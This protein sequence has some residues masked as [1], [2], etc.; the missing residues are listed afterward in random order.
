MSDT[1]DASTPTDATPSSEQPP[2]PAPSAPTPQPSGEE[3]RQQTF[4]ADY[5][6]KLRAESAR[7]RTEAKANADAAK[8]L[9]EIEDAQ[10]TEAQKAAEQLQALQQENARLQA[11]ALKAQVAASKGVPADLLSG[12]TED[13]LNAAADRLLAFKG[14]TPAPD[15]GAGNRGETLSPIDELRRALDQAIADG[16]VAA[17][18]TLKRR[19]AAQAQTS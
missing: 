12:T 15:F 16:N 11:E 13:E 3:T 19:I 8:R 18:V 2:Q 1:P 9:A 10:K 4:D 17:Q 6:A 5:V 7:Y 14:A